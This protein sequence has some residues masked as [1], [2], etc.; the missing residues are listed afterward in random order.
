VS[1]ALALGAVTAV[2]KNLL[3]NAVVNEKLTN[4]VGPVKVS[5][6][7]PDKVKAIDNF[8][9]LNLF[10]YHVQPNA[11]WRNRQQ[12]SRDFN[13]A[14]VTNPPLALDLFY[15]LTAWGS[16][17]FE[18]EIL[19]GYAMQLFH[20]IPVLSRDVI[21]KTFE[22]SPVVN[23]TILP[24][25]YK[26]LAAAS[27]ATQFEL[28]KITTYPM[29]AEESSKLWSAIQ[30]N[31]RPSVAYQVSVVLIDSEAPVKIS[32]PVLT[33]NIAGQANTMS[34]FPTLISV[35]APDQQPAARLGENITVTGFNFG[36][37]PV[38]ALLHH[39]A[40]TVPPIA[41]AQVTSSEA[42]VPLPNNPAVWPAGNYSL[43]LEVGGVTKHVSNALPVSVAPVIDMPGSSAARDGD[44][45]LIVS[46]H[47][48]PAVQPGQ[49]AILILGDITALSDPHPNATQ[50]LTFTF[51]NADAPDAGAT[52]LIRL[53]I[54]GVESIFIDRSQTP[55]VFDDT[56][57]MTL[58]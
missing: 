50:D 25:K 11:G 31:Y 57:R 36:G 7:A 5:A 19:L 10:L 42:I 9:G 40:K 39:S 17:D 48:S 15:L 26:D 14:R 34:P 29:S 52:P 6:L 45:N 2:L 47:C 46:I 20:E 18:A 38:R 41:L 43:E 8:V 16:A 30:V 24:L 27:L 33:R 35:A 49:N 58:P 12:P 51:L 13:G 28:L 4:A 23:G 3:D 56:Q 37:M 32:L 44:Q 53:R 1:N 55:P 22:S 21:R 54:D